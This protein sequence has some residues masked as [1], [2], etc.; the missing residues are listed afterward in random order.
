MF[1]I[2]LKFLHILSRS[3]LF[4]LR[5]LNCQQTLRILFILF[6]CNIPICAAANNH[7]SILLTTPF[8]PYTDFTINTH[9]DPQYQDM[10]PMDLV[11]VSK[12]SG[13]TNYRL[14]FITD[15]G[16][17]TPA[18]GGQ[19]FYAIN[20]SWGKHM[21][22]K[23][24]SNNIG[25]IIALGGAT[26]NDLSANCDIPQL[27]AV[28][29][30]I[31]K[32]YQPQGLD[33]DIE[34]GTVNINKLIVAIKQIQQNH[35]EITI[36]F[37]VPVMPEGLTLLGKQ[38]ISQAKDASL[39]Y[40]INIMAMD[41]GPGYI[42]NMGEYAIQAATSVFNFLKTLYPDHSDSTIWKMIEIT[43]MIGVND[44]N[45]EQFTLQDVDILRHFANKKNIGGLSLWS[46]TRDNP[47]PD[48]WASPI[49]SGNNLQIVPYEFS[50]HFE[51][52]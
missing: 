10:E 44:I 23:L 25:Y 41:Y 40:T 38:V 50:L 13:I 5:N 35:P 18:W 15:A 22:D 17:C 20:A 49:C 8:S 51:M 9:W 36:S 12:I 42:G 6:V 19:S 2:L 24:R 52:Q 16:N 47:C 34:N 37:T 7:P 32:I 30:Q 1:N 26:G 27:I 43:P 4:S 31:I 14:A 33:F 3:P 21:T 11:T 45:V 46:I 48:K 39:H 28:F 29:E